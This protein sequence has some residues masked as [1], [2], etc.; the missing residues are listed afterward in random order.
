MSSS[1]HPQYIKGIS[2]TVADV[3]S[4]YPTTNDPTTAQPPP[5][6]EQ[7]SELFAG[8]ALDCAVSP[9]KLSVIAA[10]QQRDSELLK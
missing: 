1:S 9:L 10:Y 4:R 2:N 3:L 6:T 8:E 5:T 7:L